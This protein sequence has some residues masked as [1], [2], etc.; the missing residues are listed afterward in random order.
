MG[1]ASQTKSNRHGQIDSDSS[2]W[3]IGNVTLW[4]QLLALYRSPIYL[5]ISS[6]LFVDTNQYYP[7]RYSKLFL[8]NNYIYYIKTI[9]YCLVIWNKISFQSNNTHHIN[10]IKCLCLKKLQCPEFTSVVLFSGKENF[11]ISLIISLVFGCDLF[12][13]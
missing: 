12:I 4:W 10:K 6:I 5:A 13:L 3:L 7:I 11:L 8:N 1:S 2:W 9:Y